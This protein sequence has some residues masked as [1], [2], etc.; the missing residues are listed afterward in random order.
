VG[1][2]D[3][4]VRREAAEE[5]TWLL[6]TGEGGRWRPAEPAAEGGTILLLAAALHSCMGGG[7]GK[8][9]VLHSAWE[10]GK[11]SRPAQSV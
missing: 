4:G 11:G 5:K 3:L 8:G 7:E 2:E 9:T 10:V 6:G 1:G